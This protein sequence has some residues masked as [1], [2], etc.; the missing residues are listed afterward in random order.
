LL[1]QA[2]LWV[3]AGPVNN[4]A[5]LYN[6]SFRLGG[7]DL[8]TFAALLLGGLLLGLCGSWLAVGRHLRSI[9]PT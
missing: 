5:G 4:L 8:V 7:T 2:S 1:V 9:E 3:L 6:S